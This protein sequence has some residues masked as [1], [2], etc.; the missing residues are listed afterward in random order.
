M[1]AKAYQVVK[2]IGFRLWVALTF[3]FT[4]QLETTKSYVE[5]SFRESLPPT[6]RSASYAMYMLGLGVP[7]IV[8]WYSAE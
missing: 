3:E 4:G 5:I 1:G 2:N 6:V 8:I 7:Q